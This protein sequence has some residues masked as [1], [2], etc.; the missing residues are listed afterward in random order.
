MATHEVPRSAGS[1]APEHR[2]VTRVQLEYASLSNAP[3]APRD[4]RRSLPHSASPTGFAP[5]AQ[6]P[7]LHGL[8]LVASVHEVEL[9]AEIGIVLLLFTIGIEFSL[10]D[11]LRIKRQVLVGGA[12]Q[13]GL[14]TAAVYG[15]AVRGVG[16]APPVA[17]FAGF[18]HDGSDEFVLL[19]SGIYF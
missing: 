6:S 13:V 3:T 18:R 17:L 7:T 14:T 5:A 16:L 1:A 8:G 4:D 9:L 10:K 2:K 12:L 19:H 15:I 11:L